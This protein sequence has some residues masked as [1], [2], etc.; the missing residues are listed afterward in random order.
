MKLLLGLYAFAT[1]SLIVIG[2]E[3]TK[4]YKRHFDFVVNHD[5]CSGS[6]APMWP[7]PSHVRSGSSKSM[8]SPEFHFKNSAKIPTLE[9]A[10]KRYMETIF[11]Y[12]TEGE[13]DSASKISHC[14]VTVEDPSEA[15]LQLETNES[16]SLYIPVQ[17][18]AKI[19]AP[20]VY[21]ALRGLETFSQLVQFNFDSYQVPATPWKIHDSPRFQHRGVMID[22]ARH[23]LPLPVIRRVIDSLV[24][25]KL[26]VLHWHMT[27]DQSFPMQSRSHPKLWEGSFSPH[28]RYMLKDIEKI[29]EYARERGVRVIVEFD[30]PGHNRSWC[31]GLLLPACPSLELL[32]I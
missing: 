32:L 20:T 7:Y 22:T 13:T 25:A 28:E 15:H 18:A 23:F 26:N 4:V 1:T 16:Y 3:Y 6:K 10:F 2:H 5:N 24:Y 12:S 27:D 29:V 11:P 19:L 8:L 30:V 9:S 21:G 31:K 17:G 14:E